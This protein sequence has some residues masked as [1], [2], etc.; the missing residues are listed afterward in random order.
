MVKK[1]VAQVEELEAKIV[2]EIRRGRGTSRLEL[3]QLLR[4]APSTVGIY[5]DRLVSE[6]FLTEGPTAG[7]R[8]ATRGRPTQFLQPSGQGGAFIGIFFEIGALHAVVVDFSGIILERISVDLAGDATAEIVVAEL[9]EVVEALRRKSSLP[10]LGIGVAV[11]GLVDAALGVAQLYAQVKGWVDLPLAENISQRFGVPVVVETNAR[12]T[13]LGYLVFDAEMRS[14]SFV[15]ILVCNTVGAGIVIDGELHRGEHFLAGEVGHIRPFLE[16]GVDAGGCHSV[17]DLVAVP[18]MIRYVWERRDSEEAAGEFRAFSEES[19]L[20]IDDIFLSA[21]RGNRLAQ[22]ALSRV[23]EGIGWLSHL[24]ALVVNPE[25]ILLS[26]VYTR[27]GEEFRAEAQLALQRFATRGRGSSPRIAFSRM[28]REI[29]VLG[30]LGAVSLAIDSWKPSRRVS[31]R[32]KH[33][34]AEVDGARGPGGVEA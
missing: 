3:A 7:R 10:L 4:L 19:A 17:A 31:T 20:T 6:G 26:G 16:G 34:A 29:G 11:P 15:N 8:P 12:A 2:R 30:V 18:G 22:A 28:C 25:V 9:Y 14:T 21:Q 23:A 1:K 13:A 33:R 32:L 24:L 27:L 5:V